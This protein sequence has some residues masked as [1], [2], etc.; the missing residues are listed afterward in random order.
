V[1][2]RRA[3]APSASR[4]PTANTVQVFGRIEPSATITNRI[5]ISRKC[6]NV[7]R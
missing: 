3:A 1:T 4:V 7:G 6:V 5:G 2:V